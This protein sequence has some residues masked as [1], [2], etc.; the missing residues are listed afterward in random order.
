MKLIFSSFKVGSLFSAKDAIPSSLRSC[1]V[2]KFS[3]AES[4]RNLCLDYCFSIID[5]AT[6]SFPLKIKESLHMTKSA[7]PECDI[8]CVK[9]GYLRLLTVHT[10]Q[11]K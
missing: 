11:T 10:S 3:C 6:T 9:R 1:V 2:Y 7:E 8:S 5:H 4:C